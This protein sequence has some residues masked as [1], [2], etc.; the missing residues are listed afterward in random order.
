MAVVEKIRC[1]VNIA[2]LSAHELYFSITFT[3][4]TYFLGHLLRLH[5][6]KV[7]E[8]KPWMRL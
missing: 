7:L 2:Y 5:C 8:V 1:S 6:S 3:N 4:Y